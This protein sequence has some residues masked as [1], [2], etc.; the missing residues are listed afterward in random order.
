MK[1]VVQRVLSA[2]LEVEGKLIS[3]IG[4]G[5]V[6]FLGVGKGDTI[7][8]ANY[9]IKKRRFSDIRSADYRK[10]WLCHSLFLPHQLI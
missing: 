7:E 1:A 9:F 6:I 2:K 5:Y 3:K 4:K 8:D 10:N